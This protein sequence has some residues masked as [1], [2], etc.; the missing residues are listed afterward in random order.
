VAEEKGRGRAGER[1]DDDRPGMTPFVSVNLSQK[2]KGE[3][4][5]SGHHLEYGNSTRK[6]G[7]GVNGKNEKG[8]VKGGG[9]REGGG[10]ETEE[11]A[12]RE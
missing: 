9:M 7:G 5:S 4:R 6:N 2:H 8:R 12:I 10:E 1:K 11:G 3:K